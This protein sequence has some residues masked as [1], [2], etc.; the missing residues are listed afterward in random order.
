MKNGIVKIKKRA[1]KAPVKHLS[2]KASFPIVG[3]G[4]SAGGFE[5]LEQFFNNMPDRKGMAFVVIQHLDP[6]R[7][8][9]L[10]ELLQRNTKM[11]VVQASDG[12]VVKPNHVYVIPPNKTMSI[13]NAVLYLF[14]PVESHGLRLPIDYFFI[15]LAEDKHEKSIGIIL[16]GMGSDG[17]IGSR[18]I[19]EK[20]GLLLVQEP[21]DAKYDNMPNSTINKCVP[22]IIAPAIE[23]PSKLLALLNLTPKAHV[24]SEQKK[25]SISTLDKIIILLRTQTRQDFS[26]YKKNTLNRRIEKRMSVHQID[27]IAG[28]LR[29]LT[30]N[31]PE[32]DIL[33]KEL[34]IGVTSFFRDPLVWKKLTDTIFPE[35]FATYPSGHVFRAWITAC[36]TGE[37]AY[38]LAIVFKEALAQEK[39]NK[40]F[41]LQVFATDIDKD[42]IMI[43]RK[44][45]FPSSI[46]SDVSAQ[47]IGDYFIK[48]TNGFRVKSSIRE[49]IVFAPHNVIRDPPFTRIDILSCRNMLIYMEPALQKKLMVLFHYSLN[50]EGI[51]LLGNAES[52]N[53]EDKT[54]TVVDSKL[55]FYR[56]TA[57]AITT[58]LFDFPSAF[59]FR[60]TEVTDLI[61]TVSSISNTPALAY[62]Q[63]I[64][65]LVPASV[66]I[67]PNADI[68]YICGK[69]GKY[70]EPSAGK[71]DMNILAMAKEGLGP[72]LGG[73]IRRAK[74]NYEKQVLRSVKVGSKDF[75]Q[76]VDVTVQQI[77]NPE[78]LKGG[79]MVIFND[80][81][82]S[83]IPEKKSTTLR[84]KLSNRREQELEYELSMAHEDLQCTREEMQATQEEL[85]SINE[86]LQSSNEEMQSANEELT[87]SKEEMFSLNE[88]LQ[89]TNTEMQN[90]LVEFIQANDDLK[91][92]LNSTD[93]ATLFLDKDLNIRRYT[94]QITQIMRLRPS[95][96]G[97]PF[98]D[99]ISQLKYPEIEKDARYVIKTLKSI[100]TT[101]AAS[102]ERWFEVK[103]MPYST[104][105]DRIEGLVITFINISTSKKL[106]DKLLLVNNELA[107]QNQLKQKRADELVIANKELVFQNKEKQKRA[108]ELVLAN[109]KLLIDQKEKK[110][111]K[112]ELEK[113][114]KELK[115]F[116]T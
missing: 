18:A 68:V 37:E 25:E 103:I 22:D 95:D 87:T 53:S 92:L 81:S 58:E 39:S 110:K 50:I 1:I 88:E 26:L 98:T 30:E 99:L 13:L 23:L 42:A 73:A 75:V 71:A 108:D 76:F 45:V 44:A 57:S 34:L 19:K 54:Y 62:E 78:S 40:N 90:K 91:N 79:I 33:F 8:G 113:T 116:K 72:P 17:S 47:R 61:K 28:Y 97:R 6:K 9:M 48:S 104:I 115:K 80:V 69:T 59:N 86:E 11:T 74:Q 112:T 56:R 96:I 14:E 67:N 64:K 102:D 55:K 82:K 46:T 85:K 114:K 12:L 101:I 15:S 109:K 51:M 2:N 63:L 84:N 36:S 107:F 32:L 111:I 29:Y 60:K 35:M 20:S 21:T 93:I 10:P 89:T 27:E 70:L 5:A 4:S 7:S 77:E 38:T 43:A 41:T 100:A 24:L 52:P 66:L 3:I 105:E 65:K 31:P 49:M 83:I 16:S 94:E 106:E